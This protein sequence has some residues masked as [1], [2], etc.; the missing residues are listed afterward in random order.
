MY[1]C[2]CLKKSYRFSFFFE[3]CFMNWLF[4]CQSSG[5]PYSNTKPPSLPNL[6]GATFFILKCKH[7]TPKISLGKWP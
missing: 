4:S 7:V 6:S 3:D 1:V 2:I 5:N